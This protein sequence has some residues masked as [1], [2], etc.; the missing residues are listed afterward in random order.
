MHFT[1][2]VCG[3]GLGTAACGTYFVKLLRPSFM[4]MAV[5]EKSVPP[6]RDTNFGTP[7]LINAAPGVFALVQNAAFC[8]HDPS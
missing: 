2:L 1:R 6:L 7:S 5:Q 4:L 8:S 3:V